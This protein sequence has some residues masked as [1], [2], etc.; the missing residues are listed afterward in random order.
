MT[1][2][3]EKSDSGFLVAMMAIRR[4][5]PRE[6]YITS[7]RALGHKTWSKVDLDWDVVVMMRIKIKAN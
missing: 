7:Y 3:H 1:K 5:R 2:G 4:S 6:I